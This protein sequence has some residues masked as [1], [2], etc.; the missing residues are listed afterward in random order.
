[1][2]TA[3]PAAGVRG[4][5]PSGPGSSRACYPPPWGRSGVCPQT[6]CWGTGVREA[7]AGSTLAAGAG[8]WV[9]E[10][11]CVPHNR[12]GGVQ[13]VLTSKL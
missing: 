5:L 12:C 11:L 10:C 4:V 2:V 7:R 6:S 3:V 8:L 13:G 9:T 1:M